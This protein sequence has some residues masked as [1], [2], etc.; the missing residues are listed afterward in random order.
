LS[1]WHSVEQG[2]TIPKI[3]FTFGITESKIWNDPNNLTLR[4]QRGNPNVL[5]PGDLVYIPDR[6]LRYESK[7][8]DRR[9]NFVL[10]EKRR[11]LL[12]IQW[13]DHD[14]QV[15]KGK[16]YVLA[17]A[18]TFVAGEFDE[19]GFI[20]QWIPIECH[21]A[22]LTVWLRGDPARPGKTYVLKIGDLDPAENMTGR[23]GRLANLALFA[24]ELTG[25]DDP[26]VEQ[27]ERILLRETGQGLVGRHGV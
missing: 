18:G 23:K 5:A 2:E 4:N 6:E 15:I 16:R 7:P 20:E 17:A 9:H 22:K 10:S 1:G 27:A 12:R 19:R 14:Y 13:I 24:G 25:D 8:V 21:E 3:A 26:D 11:Q